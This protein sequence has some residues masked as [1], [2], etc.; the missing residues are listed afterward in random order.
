M[1]LDV[2]TFQAVCPLARLEPNRGVAALVDGVQVALFRTSEGEIFAVGNQ[3]PISHAYVMSRGIVG[4]RGDAPTVASPLH[5][6]VYDLRTGDCL[7]VP[8]VTLPV[9][10]ARVTDDAV[11]EVA[12]H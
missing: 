4:S 12:V 9:Y 8:G 6:Q 2:Q 10:P 7:D 5:K 1:I 11:V 3:D